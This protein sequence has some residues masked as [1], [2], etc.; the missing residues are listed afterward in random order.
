MAANIVQSIFLF[1]FGLG[2][3]WWNPTKE[4]IQ[5][6]Y[7]DN[8]PSQVYWGY[9]IK[10]KTTKGSYITFYKRF[11]HHDGYEVDE[12]SSDDNTWAR[13]YGNSGTENLVFVFDRDKTLKLYSNNSL[14]KTFSNVVEISFLSLDAGCN[15][16]LE[17]SSFSIKK[18]TKYGTAKPMIEDAFAMMEQKNWY[19][20]SKLLSEVMDKVGYKDFKTYYLKGY[21]QLSQENFRT[22]IEYFSK[23][24][25][26]PLSTETERENAYF[27]RGYCKAQLDDN[28]CVN[29]MRKAGEDGMIWLKENRLEDYYPNATLIREVDVPIKSDNSLKKSLKSSNKPPLKK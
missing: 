21:C 10:V 11:C 13:A 9:T 19:G 6:G 16:K 18:T 27:C 17:T 14:I 15:S 7:K 22:A 25:S 1:P 20:A 5:Y 28:D 2:S 3:W 29:D 8:S 23:A 24:I 4:T 12:L 26:T